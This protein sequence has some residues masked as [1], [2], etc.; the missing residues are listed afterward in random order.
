[1]THKQID[2]ELLTRF[3]RGELSDKETVRIENLLRKDPELAELS[4]LVQRMIEG[5]RDVEWPKIAKAIE[6]VSDRM[7]ADF[8][9]SQKNKQGVVIYDSKLLPLP[10]DIRPAAID[11]RRLKF[12]LGDLTIDA[13]S[14]PLTPD[15]FELIGQIRDNTEMLNLRVTAQAGGKKHTADCDKFGLFRF[16]RLGRDNYEL[17]LYDG[18]TLLGTIEI[19]L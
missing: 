1:M 5:S 11:S 10:S 14:Y 3:H 15:S 16:E 8:Q 13:S 4:E 18:R 6:S 17:H 9:R 7:F 12:R 2:V 19:D